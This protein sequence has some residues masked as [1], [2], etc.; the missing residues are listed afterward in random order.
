LSIAPSEVTKTNILNGGGG[1]AFFK[2]L[3]G[4]AYTALTAVSKFSGGGWPL[5]R[6]LLLTPL[7]TL[8]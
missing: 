8:D 6:L 2:L 1:S 7:L 5:S 3:L 4:R